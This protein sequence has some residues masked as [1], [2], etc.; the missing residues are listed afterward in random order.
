MND[1]KRGFS[2]LPKQQNSTTALISYQKK[3][4]TIFY[5]FEYLDEIIDFYNSTVQ[6]KYNT[7][8][9]SYKISEDKRYL[10]N[11]FFHNLNSSGKLFQ[12]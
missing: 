4:F 2:W 1:Q 7:Q 11:R 9:G 6:S 10:T 3:N 12:S 8:L 5:K